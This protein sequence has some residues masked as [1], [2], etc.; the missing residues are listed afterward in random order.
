MPGNASSGC[1]MT[2]DVAQSNRA[3]PN[4][5]PRND[6]GKKVPAR[7]Q[8][9]HNDVDAR[10]EVGNNFTFLRAAKGQCH[11]VHPLTEGSF[12]AGYFV[13][14]SATALEQAKELPASAPTSPLLSAFGA[15]VDG[16]AFADYHRIMKMKHVEYHQ[17][18][19][20]NN[21]N[22]T[23]REL[24]KQDLLYSPEDG[25]WQN[26]LAPAAD[27]GEGTVRM[28]QSPS[29]LHYKVKPQRNF[30]WSVVIVG[31]VDLGDRFLLNK[32]N[33]TAEKGSIEYAFQL[34]LSQRTA[35]HLYVE[36]MRDRQ[37][38]VSVSVGE[39]NNS[40][41][42]FVPW[43]MESPTLQFVNC[44][45]IG[46]ADLVGHLFSTPSTW[47]KSSQ[48]FGMSGDQ[49]GLPG[50]PLDSPPRQEA[51]LPAAEVEDVPPIS[52]DDI[53]DLLQDQIDIAIGTVRERFNLIPRDDRMCYS[54]Q[55]PKST[56]LEWV[57]VCKFVLLKFKSIFAFVEEEGGLPYYSVVCRKLIDGGGNGTFFLAHDDEIRTPDLD[58]FKYL[59]AEVLFVLGNLKG[60]DGVRKAF[61]HFHSSL[62]TTIMTPEMLACWLAEQDTP[63]TTK[64]I[65]RFGR[66]RDDSF[67]TGNMWFRGKLI[68]P[69]EM[70][71]Y[72]I[73]PEYF[74]D[75]NKTQK[76]IPKSQYPRN[77][78]IPQCHIRY[79]IGCQ[80]WTHLYPQI[81]RNNNVQARCVFALTVAGFYAQRVWAGQGAGKQFPV[82]WLYSP[83]HETGKS[84]AMEAGHD[85]TG[86]FVCTT[87]GGS[88]T[89]AVLYELLNLQS[90]MTLMVDDVVLRN[91]ENSVMY[92]T[93]CRQVAGR[94]DRDVCNKSRT[95]YSGAC[96]A[97]SPFS[98]LT[99][100]P[101][102]PVLPGD[103][104]IGPMYHC[105]LSLRHG[106]PAL[107]NQASCEGCWYHGSSLFLG[108]KP[109][110][111]ASCSNL[112]L[113]SSLSIA[114]S[115]S[116]FLFSQCCRV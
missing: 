104:G 100:F 25:K 24:E 68:L 86:K 3:R 59:E 65:T 109:A 16:L 48:N 29:G 103:R 92:G 112:S 98:S 37:W 66:Q 1:T 18:T 19:L 72:T 12:E 106:I 53:N 73:V 113:L 96:F 2:S 11:G 49:S 87:T 67:V 95:P 14:H 54:F 69:L 82:G 15:A 70:S 62:I 43:N 39:I 84:E 105:S 4:H 47:P 76:K 7:G 40:T 5:G 42:N 108:L 6:K 89:G 78:F 63:P 75:S 116:L 8:W 20:D 79:V 30:A 32:K 81:F 41:Y 107:S 111:R 36:G 114:L 51:P 17:I 85:V 52:A 34:K 33:E 57:S 55:N 35:A 88:A 97:V 77:I 110:S 27:F 90:D 102:P 28:V 22:L 10:A 56:E 93:L 38:C 99:H 31:T 9:G 74:V 80:I 50:G 58:G 91:P 83:E 26:Y 71:R 44:V 101:S 21:P 64:C 23:M 94:L 13:L 45:K 61:V 115:S 60:M 46:N